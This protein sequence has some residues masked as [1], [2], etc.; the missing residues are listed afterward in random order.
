M[1]W[2]AAGSDPDHGLPTRNISPRMFYVHIYI[3][4]LKMHSGYCW[5][6]QTGI[7]GSGELTFTGETGIWGEK[8]LID[9]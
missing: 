9:G 1:D 7:F 2:L 8:D 5:K 3:S 6:M 4:N